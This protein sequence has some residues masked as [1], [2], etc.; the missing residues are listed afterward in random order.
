MR[1]A[2]VGGIGS[3]FTLV[4]L[5]RYIDWQ[6]PDYNC[7]C[8]NRLPG[9]HKYLLL[10]VTSLFSDSSLCGKWSCVINR[11]FSSSGSQWQCFSCL[12]MVWLVI[13]SWC[14]SLTM[15][16]LINKLVVVVRNIVLKHWGSSSK[17]MKN[18]L[19]DSSVTN[20]ILFCIMGS[21]FSKQKVKVLVVGLD[22]SGKTSVL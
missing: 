7:Y 2:L 16:I 18:D 14:A 5:L 12:F 19:Y 11:L 9:L 8:F 10:P 22:N 1:F 3:L 4:I 6:T 15:K 20:N 17:F 13:L 21:A